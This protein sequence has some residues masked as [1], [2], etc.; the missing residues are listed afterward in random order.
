M[1]AQPSTVPQFPDNRRE[2]F[3]E[4]PLPSSDESE[5]VILGAILLDNSVI[6]QVAETLL[7]DEFYS[8]FHRM[9]YKGMLSL[10]QQGKTIDP[11]LI[12][13]E[14]KHIG[15]ITF[16]GGISTITNLTFG[17]PH[18][19]KIDEYIRIVQDHAKR[20]N[21]ARACAALQASALDE[22]L[23]AQELFDRAEQE[24]FSLSHEKTKHV[25]E[26]VRSLIHTVAVKHRDIA[27]RI[28]RGEKLAVGVTTGLADLDKITG[29]WRR[30]DLIIMAG[31]PSMG[32]TSLGVQ[33]AV[34]AAMSDDD[35][36]KTAIFS[37]EMTKEQL[38]NR[39]LCGEARV[40][41]F[42]WQQGYAR[43]AEFER[44]AEA[45]GEFPFGRC[46]I[47][48]EAGITPMQLR[49][50]C[51]R[52]ITE[53]KRLDLVVVDYLGMMNPST[54]VRNQ[55]LVQQIGDITKELKAVAKDLD[56]PILVL[57]QLSRAP[58]GR[59]PPRPILSDLRDSGAIEQ[60]ADVVLF[61]Y[62]EEY[63]EQLRTEE[64]NGLAEIIVAKQR[65]GPTDTV[66]TAFLREFTRFENFVQG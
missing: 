33:C 54:K 41:S 58:E 6:A 48:D 15:D 53:H 42:R 44:V 11:I 28:V 31:R 1:S 56:L 9:V 8:P 66:A 39:I 20:R 2:S 3:L 45:V 37:L 22:T 23:S 43:T 63:Y 51:R 5:R 61:V 36:Y 10:F 46:F 52:L 34:R 40:D 50:K 47:D 7:P 30:G 27:E 17:L 13:E 4:R 24:I 65:N 21:L 62:R 16:M 49:A 14:L 26:D 25:A 64:N 32:K 12:N 19:T 29:G 35:E 59:N 18:F 57:S 60:D 55:S 38:A